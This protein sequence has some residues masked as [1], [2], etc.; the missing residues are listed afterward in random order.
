MRP[1]I[2]VTGSRNWHDVAT[3]AYALGVTRHLFPDMILVHGACPSGADKQAEMW[4]QVNLYESSIHRFPANWSEGKGAGYARNCK[5]VDETNPILTLAF[6]AACVKPRCPTFIPHYSH[7]ATQC[8]T[9]AAMQ[10]SYVRRFEE[11]LR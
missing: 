1:H 10:G 5:M 11:P 8:A 2:L 3:L 4:A 7:G 9:Y 6:L